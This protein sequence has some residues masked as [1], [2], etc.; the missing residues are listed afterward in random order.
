[1]DFTFFPSNSKNSNFLPIFIC[2]SPIDSLREENMELR[3][4]LRQ[5]EIAESNLGT[6]HKFEK[7]ARKKKFDEVSDSNRIPTTRLKM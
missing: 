1:M 5:T 7:E 6:S 4:E 2:I 3:A